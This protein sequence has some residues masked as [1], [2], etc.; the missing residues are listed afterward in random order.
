MGKLLADPEVSPL[1]QEIYGSVLE[2]SQRFEE[3]FD[4]PLSD[5]LKIPNGEAAIAILPSGDP[6][7]PPVVCFMLEAKDN[8]P[9]LL[10]L[11]EKAL[12]ES[13]LESAAAKEVGAI[14]V[15]NKRPG[16]AANEGFAYFVDQDVFVGSNS[17]E[18]IEYSARVWQ[19]MESEHKSLAQKAD[20]VSILS[21]CTGAQGERPQISFYVDPLSLAK[22]LSK[23]NPGAP[24]IFAMLP[25]LG[26]DGIK[27]FGG[28]MILAP[29]DFDSIA[30]FHVLLGSPRRVILSA[31]R[32]AEGP[33]DP[34]TWVPEDVAS[35]MT[36]NWKTQPTIN[37]VQE[38]IDTFQGPDTF[39]NAMQAASKELNLD[40]KKDVLDQIDDRFTIGSI[41]VRP[42]RINSQSN[43]YA[44]KIKDPV[45]FE[46][47]TLPK[48]MNKIM[49]RDKQFEIIDVGSHKVYHR[50]ADG[51]T[52]DGPRFPDPA[53]TVL[54]SRLITGDSLQVIE[55]VCEAY[56]SGE[57]LLLESIEYKLIRQRIE[58]QTKGLQLSGLTM[59]RPEE[60]LRT[61]Y[62]MAADPK[63]RQ[64]LSEMADMNPFFKALNTAL[65]KHQLPPFDVI[66]KH[67]TPSGGFLSE[68]DSGLHFMTFGLKRK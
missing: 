60:S 55:R 13:N 8:M 51:Q 50:K 32:P 40:F 35:Y 27:G 12:N 25:P 47:E 21:R 52:A 10:D 58:A 56:D 15:F 38:L 62:D 18:Y 22:E 66:R 19:G 64:R 24:L 59:S 26:I 43:F 28:S 30:H 23:E 57:K 3:R 54:D 37:A 36:V 67:M 33:V 44:V 31:V 48:I 29:Q 34:E 65:T 53:A 68:D 1:I 39:A 45:R 42:L 16:A 2:S 9:Q 5:A 46:S 20:F 14:R 49:E 61:F 41:F 4:M 63:N 17:L 6:T 7:T 11:L